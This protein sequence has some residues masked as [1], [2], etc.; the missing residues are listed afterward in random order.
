MIHIIND[1]ESA[2]GEFSLNRSSNI[3]IKSFKRGGKR[4]GGRKANARKK[5][6]FPSVKVIQSRVKR[7]PTRM[8]RS[9]RK[10]KSRNRSGPKGVKRTSSEYRRD[11]GRRNSR[12][13]FGNLNINLVEIFNERSKAIRKDFKM[14]R[15]RRV[16]AKNRIF[17]SKRNGKRTGNREEERT[18]VIIMSRSKNLKGSNKSGRRSKH[19]INNTRTRGVI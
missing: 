9:R 11:P 8:S 4:R 17:G 14:I 6:R 18:V 5:S 3:T 15:M 2:S 12:R 1:T 19:K 13:K 16:K 7:G 10:A